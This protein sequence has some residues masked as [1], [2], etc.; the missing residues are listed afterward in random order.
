MKS[1]L[2]SAASIITGFVIFVNVY[3]LLESIDAHIIS[4]SMISGRD[5]YGG[6]VFFF[7]VLATLVAMKMN[8]TLK[9]QVLSNE[10]KVGWDISV[11]GFFVWYLIMYFGSRLYI[12]PPIVNFILGLV[13][14]ALII[15]FFNESLYK[16]EV[17]RLNKAAKAKADEEIAHLKSQFIDPTK[18]QREANK[19]YK[20]EFKKLES[21]DFIHPRTMKITPLEDTKLFRWKDVTQYCIYQEFKIY[22]PA[23]LVTDADG[24]VKGYILD[25]YNETDEW[26]PFSAYKIFENTEEI[27]REDFFD[28]IDYWKSNSTG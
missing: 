5:G 26:T 17:D 23:V 1:K 12:S 2:I 20:E 24:L 28:D 7:V 15:Y 9:G 16:P 10:Q 8:W 14:T 13:I 3:P 19:K 11:S 6:A 21:T 22:G 18:E 4:D 25:S 27:S